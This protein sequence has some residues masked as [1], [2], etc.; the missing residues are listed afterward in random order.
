[1]SFYALKNL[2]K[3]YH[4]WLGTFYRYIFVIDQ[5]HIHQDSY[6]ELFYQESE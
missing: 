4:N 1:M 2:N 3:V 6:Q 5:V